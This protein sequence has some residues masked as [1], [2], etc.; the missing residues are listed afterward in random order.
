[1]EGLAV[2]WHGG[3]RCAVSGVLI[4]REGEPALP[5]KNLRIGAVSTHAF[6]VCSFRIN[7]MMTSG[8][9][10]SS[11]RKLPVDADEY[12]SLEQENTS[13]KREIGKLT[14]EMK[15]LSEVLKDHEKI[16]PLLHCTMNFVTVPRPDALASCLPR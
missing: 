7:G 12:E 8:Q 11:S 6:A 1:M 9:G 5:G 4:A 15:H 2:C 16:C 10:S 13:L 14:D 3:G